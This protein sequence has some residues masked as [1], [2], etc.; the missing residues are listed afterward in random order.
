MGSNRETEWDLFY[1]FTQNIIYISKCNKDFFFFKASRLEQLPQTSQ[2]LDRGLLDIL[3][4]VF[5]PVVSENNVHKKPVLP[6]SERDCN[7]SRHKHGTG[8]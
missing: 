2:K 7:N 4:I 8:I 5:G 6:V 3:I 1:I